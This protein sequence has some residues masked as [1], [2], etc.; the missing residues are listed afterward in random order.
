MPISRVLVVFQGIASHK[1]LGKCLASGVTKI[2]VVYCQLAWARPLVLLAVQ[3][4][5]T[6]ASSRAPKW[7]TEHCPCKKPS[8][9]PTSPTLTIRSSSH[10]S[11]LAYCSHPGDQSLQR[12]RK[13]ASNV[14]VLVHHFEHSVSLLDSVR[15]THKL[16]SH[17]RSP[18]QASA[19]TPRPVACEVV[20]S[21]G[22]IVAAQSL[23][24]VTPPF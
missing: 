16:R 13:E 10:A 21:I 20:G 5:L 1:P 6:A 24:L 12:P 23:L 8:E 4:P 19:A 11:S 9:P 22:F 7:S 15:C 2:C 17:Q 14:R 18:S 3:H